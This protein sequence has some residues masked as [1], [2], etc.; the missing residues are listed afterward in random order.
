VSAGGKLVVA[1][2]AARRFLPQARAL[3]R[4]LARLHPG[5]RLEALLVDEA[6]NGERPEIEPFATTSISA[7][8]FPDLRRFR[9]RHAQR[10]VAIA[11]KP[12][13]LAHL[14]ARDAGR[15]LF[16]DADTWALAPLDP[17][18][19]RV[20]A[21]DLVLT[22][23]RTRPARGA[24][25]PERELH[26]LRCGT[27]NGGV[28]AMSR[29]ARGFALW[30]CER[31]SARYSHDVAAGLHGDQ[32]WLDLAPGLV[33]DTCVFR[34][35]GV[36]VAHW[37][38]DERPLSRRGGALFAGETLCRLFH[39]SGFDPERPESLTRHAPFPRIEAGGELAALV[40]S[41]RSELVACGLERDG[42]APDPSGRFDD[43]TPIPE[44]ARELHETCGGPVASG[45]P[46]A[47]GP[48]SYFEWLRGGDPSCAGISRLWWA[49]RERRADLRA[50]FPDP[51][52]IDRH[53]FV[54]WCESSGRAEH[55]IADA[56]PVLASGR[57]D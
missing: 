5:L 40:A 33:R 10:G 46:F 39:W 52:S 29:A 34:D 24:G 32:R 55:A 56:F 53:A 35:P 23:H 12:Y 51:L 21:H 43:G 42:A 57:P 1:T 38:L 49:I 54:T 25:A 7:I 44:L 30:W 9:F 27:Y 50:A 2:I 36:N 41:Y 14:L 26:L 4:S 48:G 31:T 6:G 18:L 11:A 3:A 19:D 17:L 13:F 16:L 20:E 28:V 47:T 15:V 37:N 8:G 45:D 22:P